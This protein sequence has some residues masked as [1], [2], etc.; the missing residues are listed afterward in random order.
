MRY[1]VL[2]SIVTSNSFYEI[3]NHIFDNSS[4]IYKIYIIVLQFYFLDCD[5]FYLRQQKTLNE[6]RLLICDIY[7]SCV[8][9]LNRHRGHFCLIVQNTP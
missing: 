7:M 5:V 9:L 4:V 8:R 3:F 6:L 1:E 2:Y